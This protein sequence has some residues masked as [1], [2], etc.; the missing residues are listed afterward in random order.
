MQDGLTALACAVG[1]GYVDITRLLLENGATM[2][3]EVT[4]R[5][6]NMMLWLIYPSL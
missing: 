1:L 5:R 2:D 4:V 3:F 6:T